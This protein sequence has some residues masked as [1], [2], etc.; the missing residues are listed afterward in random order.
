MDENSIGLYE[1]H[2][3]LAF[4]FGKDY[5]EINHD[6]NYFTGWLGNNEVSNS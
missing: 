6:P 1:G 3:Y 2:R 4:T 5:D